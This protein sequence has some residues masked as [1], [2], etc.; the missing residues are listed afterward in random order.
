MCR[1]GFNDQQSRLRGYP[2]TDHGEAGSSGPRPDAPCRTELTYTELLDDDGLSTCFSK[3]HAGWGKSPH[4]E[5]VQYIPR[6]SSFLPKPRL[7][8]PCPGHQ[9]RHLIMDS[10]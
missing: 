6:M 3:R 1:K 10:S 9:L 2:R 5:L 7:S 8:Q 4:S